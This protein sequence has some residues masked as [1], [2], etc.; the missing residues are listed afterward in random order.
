M[1]HSRH[2][3]DHT[4]VSQI[5]MKSKSSSSKK[6]GPFIPYIPPQEVSWYDDIPDTSNDP[7]SS[8]WSA[9]PIAEESSMAV[10][11]QSTT[12]MLRTSKSISITVNTM[13]FLQPSVHSARIDVINMASSY[14]PYVQ[15]AGNNVS[16]ANQ[17]AA[18]NMSV[19]QGNSPISN[20][21]PTLDASVVKLVS[22]QH[23]SD[24]Q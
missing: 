16:V 7:T 24:S 20:T 21:E 3:I 6:K 23:L 11:S 1:C 13:P 4:H 14:S 10:D 2:N 12:E 8:S 9:D 17:S 19:P 22:L 15:T 18:S 5:R